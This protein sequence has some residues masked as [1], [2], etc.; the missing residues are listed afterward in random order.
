MKYIAAYAMCVLSG[1][2]EPSKADI[3]KVLKDAGVKAEDEKVQKVVDSLK[4]KAFHE[5]VK[6]GL[7]KLSSSATVVVAAPAGGAPVAGKPA[8]AK[9]EEPKEEEAADVDMA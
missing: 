5:L 9:K 3:E 6:S 4:G 8:E 1:K 2:A 7:S